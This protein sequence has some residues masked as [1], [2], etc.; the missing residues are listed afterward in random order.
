MMTGMRLTEQ[1]LM[2]W[3]MV[4]LNSCRLV[5]VVVLAQA[6]K[7]VLPKVWKLQSVSPLKSDLEVGRILFFTQKRA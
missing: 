7:T 4:I 3:L 1:L 6:M 2:P 5:V